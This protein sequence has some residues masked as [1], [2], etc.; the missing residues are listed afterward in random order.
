MDSQNSIIYRINSRDEIVFVNE[1]WDE[2][3][4]SQ[5]NL[6]LLGQNIRGRVIWDF[7]SDY[8]TRDLYR[9]IIKIVRFGKPVRFNFRCDSPST[10][11]LMEMN[12]T[13]HD[14]EVQFESKI[15]RAEKRPF[16]RLLSINTFR[17]DELLNLC[18]WCNKVNV[19]NDTWSEVEDAVPVMRIFENDKL[20]DISHGICGDCY[21]PW[22]KELTEAAKEFKQKK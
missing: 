1:K 7:I 4:R 21:K 22:I 18:G 17:S 16:Q 9:E 20:P 19:E 10:R 13:L 8:V 11:R 3:V 12:I 15:I 14:D 5:N 6:T 2:T